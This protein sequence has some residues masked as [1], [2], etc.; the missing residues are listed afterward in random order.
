MKCLKNQLGIALVT[1]L[2]MTLI[3]LVIVMGLMTLVTTGIQITSAGKRYKTVIEAGY[4][5]VSLTVNEIIPSL[6]SAMFG[7]LPQ[8]GTAAGVQLLLEKYGKLSGTDL[9][10]PAMACLQS[11]LDNVTADWGTK[12]NTQSVSL[13]PKIAPDFTFTLKSTLKGFR[14]GPGFIVY[15]KIV[16]T[17]IKGNTD[18]SAK[19]NLRKAENITES[20]SAAGTGITIPTTYRIEIRA[21]SEN[22][23]REKANISVVYAY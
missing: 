4:G 20:D 10:L 14:P 16:D 13:D 5:G 18:K 12:C 21:E 2:L 1:S 17:P 19:A 8:E 11:K 7:G 22:N 3:S 23:P 6:N 9:K 15:S